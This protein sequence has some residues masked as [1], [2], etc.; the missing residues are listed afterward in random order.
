MS[1]DTILIVDDQEV[2]RAILSILFSDTHKILEAEDGSRAIE[3]LKADSERIA[4]VLLDILMPGIDGF[5]VLEYMKKEDLMKSIP[6]IFVTGASDKDNEL[7]GRGYE[8]GVSDFIQKPFDPH[9]VRRRVSNLIDLYYHKNHLEEQVEAQTLEIQKKNEH[10]REM[11]YRIIDTLGTIVEFR[12]LESGNHIFR[13]RSYTKVLLSY[14][15]RDYPEYKLTDEVCEQIAQA[16]AM[17]D[18]GKISIPDSILLKP[19]K[20]TVEEFEIMKTHTTKGCEIIEKISSVDDERFIRCCYEIARGHHEKYDGGGYPDGLKGDEIP[21]SAQVVSIADMYDALVSDR[22]YKK[23]F[24]KDKAYSM[25]M[26]GEC[27][28]LNPKLL[29]CFTHARM[30]FEATADGLK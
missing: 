20:L 6:V 9:I 13:V 19:G 17:H 14:V 28:A 7:R 23:A 24:S 15:K 11:N 3:I 2:N 8:M 22:V 21:L 18:V 27:G 30:E 4:V 12:N 10:L 25:I 26:N 5:G 16:S 1:K 29:E